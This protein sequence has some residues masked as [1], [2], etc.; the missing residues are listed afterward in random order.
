MLSLFFKYFREG[1]EFGFRKELHRFAP[2]IVEKCE[3][4]HTFTRYIANNMNIQRD[5]ISELQ[6]WKER[7]DRK[8]LIFQGARQIGKTTAIR[9]FGKMN[10]EY[11][12]E[13]N[14]DKTLELKDLFLKTKD[15]K[16]ILQE[17]AFFTDVPI[18]PEKT[19]L[20]FDEIQECGE[21]LNTLKYF[22]EEAPQ[23]HIIAA[24]S[25][26]GVALNRANAT[27]P[28]GKVNYLQMYP[29]TF[30]EYLRATDEY[31]FEYA[32]GIKSIA[33]LP[34]IL[35]NRFLEHYRHYQVCGGLPYITVAMLN[36]EGMA[37]IE[38][39]LQE[40]LNSYA[41]DFSKHVASKDITR[42]HEIWNSLPSQLSR[43]NKKFIFRVIREGARAREY[44]SALQWLVLAGLAYK[45]VVTEKPVLPLSFYEDSTCFKI[46]MLDAGLLRKLA[47]LPA[48][49]LL[50]SNALFSEFKGAVAE[51]M[52][53]TSLL[54]QGYDTPHYWTLQGNKAE[55]DFLIGDG[56]KILPIEVKSD[57][58]I[59]GKS[60][61]E[62]DK[63]YHPEL[64]IRFSLKN[65]KMD[66]NLLNIPLYLGDWTRQLVAAAENSAE[67]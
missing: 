2:S 21:A 28:V 45:V 24:G 63:K 42:I 46:Y 61:A 4:N 54:A 5:I 53:L 43:E 50:A 59:S 29:V 3:K 36:G 19:L 30:R 8:P 52:I 51:N 60:F 38:D 64:R 1:K 57:E 23:Y 56:L 18:Q 31:L 27:F 22:D 62:Y 37:A 66:G 17:L 15:V 12:A 16:R 33:P 11:V 20:F 14:F 65:L 25:L 58:R 6:H 9:M 7:P 13:F 40:M 67:K 26:L 44:E 39:K 55:V 32:N 48:E 35:N 41:Y 10:F 47:R 34:E 49:V